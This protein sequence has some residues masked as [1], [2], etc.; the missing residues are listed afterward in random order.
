MS[1]A[2]AEASGGAATA[3]DPGP[4]LD[5]VTA[6]AERATRAF[7]ERGSAPAA[8]TSDDIDVTIEDGE[9]EPD[10]KAKAEKVEEEKR[11]KKKLQRLTP[12]PQNAEEAF[13]ARL[14]ARAE[15]SRAPAQQVDSQAA[16]KSELERLKSE[17]LTSSKRLGEFEAAAKARDPEAFAK[18]GGWDSVE[19][20]TRE[21][22]KGQQEK[23]EPTARE[24][25]LAARLEKLESEKSAEQKAR[26]ERAAK[27]A[28]GRDYQEQLSW[29]REVAEAH[30]VDEVRA[31][32]T[33][34]PLIR[35]N[36]LASVHEVLV[37]DPNIPMDEAYG[38][39]L[40]NYKPVFK[41]LLAV[42]PELVQ[43]YI[44][45]QN[46]AKT[47]RPQGRKPDAAR[48]STSGRDRTRQS[49][50][51]RRGSTVEGSK[52]QPLDSETTAEKAER[53][54]AENASTWGDKRQREFIAKLRSA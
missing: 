30:E 12:N 36:F 19:Q 54:T 5:A 3:A 31:A 1:E 6:A 7:I 40:D 44:E 49:E 13:R 32:V 26:E 28:E 27:E 37:N 15:A 10:A 8:D 38:L 34:D 52:K 46:S 2:G 14:K 4:S 25:E 29:I 50:A 18:L 47:E 42:F 24:K 20:F 33:S 17:G 45:S 48:G 53:L 39:V 41:G 23:P 11:E 22:L 21:Y 43:E 35:D 51:S 16:M 9:P